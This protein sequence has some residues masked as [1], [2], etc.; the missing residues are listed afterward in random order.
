MKR[1]KPP[2]PV[3]ISVMAHRG[4][5]P[6]GVTAIAALVRGRG[7]VMEGMVREGRSDLW[8]ET[9]ICGTQGKSC[10]TQEILAYIDIDEVASVLRELTR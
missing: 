3:S 10:S 5:P 1:P 2:P 7:R 6:S 8:I 9:S 4:P